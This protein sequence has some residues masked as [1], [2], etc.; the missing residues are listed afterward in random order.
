MRRATGKVCA[1]LRAHV[2]R[3]TGDSEGIAAVEFAMILPLMMLVYM[4]VL[5]LS[6]GYQASRKAALVARSLADVVSQAS[7]TISS[8]DM[9]N[10]R[11]TANWIMAPFKI[12]SG[13]LRVTLSSVLFTTTGAPPVK[14]LVDWSVSYE[15][16]KQ[17]RA[18]S[19]PLTQV[20]S[21]VAPALTNIPSGLV[22]S[23]STI[24]VADIAYD[25]KP[26]LAGDNFQSFG[27]GAIGSI[28]LKQTAFMRPRNLTRV[29]IDATLQADAANVNNCNAAF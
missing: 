8:T 10:F 11:K 15:G 27:G 3:F 20:A 17:R 29:A 4:G 18:C 24:I 7:T 19:T 1:P 26:L 28:T 25:Y 12:G 9:A 14:A 22:A 16:L 2:D 5:E 21:T 6:Q 13:Q 23:G